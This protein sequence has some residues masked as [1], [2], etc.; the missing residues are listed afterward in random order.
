M[1]KSMIW[2]LWPRT[3]RN[4]MLNRIH[5]LW[6]LWEW[7]TQES[8]V[9]SL[10]YMMKLES[11]LFSCHRMIW[12]KSDHM[13]PHTI[14]KD[15]S[16]LLITTHNSDITPSMSLEGFKKKNT[17]CWW[18]EGLHS[19]RLIYTVLQTCPSLHSLS[20]SPTSSYS[21]SIL[22]SSILWCS[23]NCVSND[24]WCSNNCLFIMKR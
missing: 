14:K 3:T 19:H 8:Y 21:Y 9:T 6:E 1:N 2:Y 11:R 7:V 4:S 15:V 20:S 23:N 22:V 17:K 24:T 16:H 18:H 10:W 5:R 12:V 13:F